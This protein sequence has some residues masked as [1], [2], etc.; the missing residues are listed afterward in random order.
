[1]TTPDMV[2]KSNLVQLDSVIMASD[3]YDYISGVIRWKLKELIDSRDK[4]KAEI[5]TETAKGITNASPYWR[6]GK[7]LI[8]VHP[9][10]QGSKRVREYIGA[11]PAKVQEA[12]NKIKRYEEVTTM[13][14]ALGLVEKKIARLQVTLRDVLRQLGLDWAEANLVLRFMDGDNQ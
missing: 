3:P 10:I 8:L 5:E 6:E 12:M 14:W 2:T 4:I 9:Q 7:F 13:Q 1:M 11:D